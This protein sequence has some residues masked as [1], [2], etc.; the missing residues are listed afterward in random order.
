VKKP[1][2]MPVPE[3]DPDT[4]P[5][6]SPADAKLFDD[7]DDDDEKPPI[8]AKDEPKTDA[9]VAD[10][11]KTDAA[12][13][14]EPKT[15]AAVADEPK[16]D[17][18]GAGDDDAVTGPGAL[19]A[20]AEVDVEDAAPSTDPPVGGETVPAPSSEPPPPPPPVERTGEVDLSEVELS[21]DAEHADV[22]DD[23]VAW[24]GESSRPPPP[25]PP[26]AGA[27]VENPSGLVEL[28]DTGERALPDDDLDEDVDALLDAPPVPKRSVPPPP[29]PAATRGS[30]MPPPPPGARPSAAPPPPPL[31]PS[32]S[33][34]KK[35]K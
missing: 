16:T 17:A 4:G 1:S 22:G 3:R 5:T 32:S 28:P 7:D 29:P 14:D 18:Q 13:A 19:L 33:R 23:E 11:P 26:P 35:K 6:V 24:S 25:P 10:E 15:D 12:V 27:F 30:S 2:Q 21:D 8:E 20:K 34:R 9:P 31:P